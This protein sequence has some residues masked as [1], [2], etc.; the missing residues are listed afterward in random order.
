M[1]LEDTSALLEETCEEGTALEVRLPE[2]A[3]VV[4]TEGVALEERAAEQDGSEPI[5]L[6]RSPL[7][8]AEPGVPSVVKF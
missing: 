4:D 5:P 3:T 1:T 2:E 7:P 6:L 8:M